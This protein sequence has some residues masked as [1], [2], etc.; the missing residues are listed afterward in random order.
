MRYG[1]RGLHP[2]RGRGPEIPCEREPAVPFARVGHAQTV[3]R[4]T[5][6]RQMATRL[7]ARPRMVTTLKVVRTGSGR[8]E[9][10]CRKPGGGRSCPW[11]ILLGDR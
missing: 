7:M 8:W 2:A 10:G 9:L 1:G 11:G 3:T 5:V 6:T 4:Q